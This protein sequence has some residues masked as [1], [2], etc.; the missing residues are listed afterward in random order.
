VYASVNVVPEA[1][2][3]GEAP[4]YDGLQVDMTVAEAG[5]GG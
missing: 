2:A 3:K 4:V 1:K 5:T